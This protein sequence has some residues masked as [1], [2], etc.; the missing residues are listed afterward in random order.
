MQRALYG[1]DGFY[2]R[3]G[4]GPAAHFRTSAH[5][6]LFAEAMLR[7]LRRADDAL[8]RP[9]QV[10]LVDVGAG[11][12]ELVGAVVELVA[13]TAPDLAARLRPCAVEVGPRPDGLAE[14]IVWASEIPE[15]VVGLLVANEWL[16]NVV[17]D[18]AEV[19]PDGA[20]RI[21]EVDPATGA[22]RLGTVPDEEQAEWLDRWWP[23][24][25]LEPGARAE[26]GIDRD[27]AWAAAVSR[28][29]RGF[30]VAI[31]YA[32][33]AGQR[34]EFGTLTGYRDGH[35]V[36]AVPDGSCDVTAHVALDACRE[37]VA[38]A[39]AT[40]NA[41]LVQSLATQRESLHRLGIDGARPPL[42][43]ATSDPLGYIRALSTASGA[44][45]LTDPDGL[46]GFGW[47]LAE[48]GLPPEGPMAGFSGH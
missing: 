31:D 42:A 43:L 8:G 46:G 44:A 38:D 23:L 41:R 14:E 21:V 1:P 12:G 40:A 2:R 3:P 22:E 4:G 30:A 34:P 13:A 37:A 11:R 9:E 33:E 18:V 45:E 19:G 24:A 28:L 5:N 15:R 47:L 39:N 26:I 10:D 20:A 27:A 16:D 7:L 35:Q 32:H 48:A 36:A 17:F 29:D 25:G 6:P